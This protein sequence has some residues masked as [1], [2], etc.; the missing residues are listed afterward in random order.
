MTYS[1]SW[2]DKISDQVQPYY[3]KCAIFK[4]LEWVNDEIPGT[5]TVGQY[6]KGLRIRAVPV[7]N[8]KQPKTLVIESNNN[9]R[10]RGK[11]N[12]AILISPSSVL[13]AGTVETDSWTITL[14]P[15]VTKINI[16]R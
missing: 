14:P 16:K 2:I 8:G 12:M 6:E 3:V 13:R 11:D 10:V 15:V 4:A 9:A 7:G 5:V 1:F